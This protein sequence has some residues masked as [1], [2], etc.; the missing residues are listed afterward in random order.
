MDETYLIHS[1]RQGDLEAFNCLVL[2]CQDLV[3]QHAV[4][5]LGEPEVAEAV[6]QEIFLRAYRG[7]R[8]F[9]GG[10]IRIWLL[11]IANRLC[12]EEIHRR[13]QGRTSPQEVSNNG[14][15]KVEATFQRTDLV[16]SPEGN[17]GQDVLEKIVREGLKGLSPDLRAVITLVD[18]QGMDYPQTAEILGISGGSVKRRLAR[19][20]WRMR[21]TLF[22]P[23]RL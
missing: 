9:Q 7:L 17:P 15:I 6:T 19:A 12:L 16:C 5:M 18:L 3:F 2:A 20:R 23:S 1:A 22:A 14:G 10:D 4:W 21:D 11:R 8:S 13:E